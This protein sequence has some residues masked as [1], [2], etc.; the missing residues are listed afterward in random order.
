VVASQ[1]PLSNALLKL[2]NITLD[3][4]TD[5][6][7]VATSG[8]ESV[9]VVE[10][11]LNDMQTTRGSTQQDSQGKLVRVAEMAALSITFEVTE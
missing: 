8:K 5:R 10:G 2:R 3:R 1:K 6:G 4:D 9:E 7:V 11:L